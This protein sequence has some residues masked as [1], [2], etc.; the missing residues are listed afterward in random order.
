M[1]KQSPARPSATQSVTFTSQTVSPSLSPSLNTDQIAEPATSTAPISMAKGLASKLVQATPPP[2]IRGISSSAILETPTTSTA[3]SDSQS[4][5][6]LPTMHDSPSRGV[7][8]A[9]SH[10]GDISGSSLLGREILGN[11]QAKSPLNR[12]DSIT[13]NASHTP[14]AVEKSAKEAAGTA[15]KSFRVNLEDPCWKVLPAALKKYKIHDDWRLYVMLIC[16]G[17]TGESWRRQ[18]SA[19][20]YEADEVF[21]LGLAERCLSYDEKPLLLFQKLKEA[22]QKP[23][24]ML[25]HIVSHCG[26][27]RTLPSAG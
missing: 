21:R 14:T 27:P 23:V 7:A 26:Y 6:G 19:L 18:S 11:A 10:V 25:R 4:V 9:V 16:F 17:N 2:L 5:S 13:K 15:A 22:N 3:G 8:T 12:S 24:F 20:L 1:A